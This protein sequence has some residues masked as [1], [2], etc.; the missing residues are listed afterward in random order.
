[1]DRSLP[2]RALSVITRTQPRALHAQ[3]GACLHGVDLSE[4]V[5]N[6]DITIFVVLYAKAH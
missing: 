6:D 3:T 2:G 4:Y 5:I 1:M